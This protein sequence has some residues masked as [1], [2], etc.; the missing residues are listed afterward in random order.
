[1]DISMAATAKQEHG[2]RFLLKGFDRPPRDALM[3]E[4]IVVAETVE[5]VNVKSDKSENEI[6]A[7]Q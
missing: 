5:T 3:T 6:G 1:M 2:S 4:V 7:G